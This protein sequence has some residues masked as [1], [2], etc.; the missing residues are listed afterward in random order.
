MSDLSSWFSCALIVSVLGVALIIICYGLFAAN[1]W[2]HRDPYR[3]GDPRYQK[4]LCFNET[5]VEDTLAGFKVAYTLDFNF[6][7]V[8][9]ENFNLHKMLKES[10]QSVLAHTFNTNRVRRLMFINSWFF[11]IDWPRA[12][13]PHE[14]FRTPVCRLVPEDGSL[15]VEQV[16]EGDVRALFWSEPF[17]GHGCK[18]EL[19]DIRLH[20]FPENIIK[21]NYAMLTE[22]QKK[23]ILMDDRY[24]AFEQ[25]LA[26]A[27][28]KRRLDFLDNKSE[29]YDGEMFSILTERVGRGLKITWR[30]K[31][32][33][34]QGYDIMG[35]RR[36]GGFHADQWDETSNGTLVV[37][38]NK[39]GE[40]VELLK[41]GEAQFYTFLLKPWQE[42]PKNTK[43]SPVRFQV[44]I[45]TVEETDAIKTTLERIERQSFNPPTQN[46]SRAL[47]ELGLYAEFD[48]AIE[49]REKIMARQ[50][51][52]AGY[53]PE[54]KEEK[55]S[56]LRD[57][58]ASVRDKY[59]Q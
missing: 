35:F 30:L 56:R 26:V 21:V 22:E 16:S 43:R 37:H 1:A 34:K 10:S 46:V 53:A 15:Y 9:N 5:F 44:T 3:E 13:G 6:E 58:V 38:S 32:A 36:T 18:V 39:D 48:N 24:G 45:A 20:R 19:V 11:H 59:Q 7:R 57:V 41:E 31:P 2:R 25:M 29:N 47:K 23:A 17:T 50:I 4:T 40:T 52:S 14:Y 55:L 49:Q 51:E 12:T 28:L 42:T 8:D 54:E 27:A 33:A